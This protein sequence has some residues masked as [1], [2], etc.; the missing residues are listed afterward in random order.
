MPHCARFSC[1]SWSSLWMWLCHL[2]NCENPTMTPL[3]IVTAKTKFPKRC[4]SGSIAPPTLSFS[5]FVDVFLGDVDGNGLS[6]I[7]VG[8]AGNPIFSSTILIFFDMYLFSFN[9]FHCFRNKTLSFTQSPPRT[10]TLLFH[11]CTENFNLIQFSS[12]PSP[13][14]TRARRFHSFPFLFPNAP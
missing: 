4:T 2:L 14:A 3:M 13:S 1:Q 5:L 10:L 11:F 12:K 8:S 9:F 6:L 7:E